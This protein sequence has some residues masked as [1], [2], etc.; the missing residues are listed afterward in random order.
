MIEAATIHGYFDFLSIVL[1]MA[2]CYSAY[3]D[4]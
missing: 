3:D 2:Q 4:P 1:T